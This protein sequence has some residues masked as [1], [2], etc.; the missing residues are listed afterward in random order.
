LLRY[1]APALDVSGDDLQVTALV[2]RL[3]QG[4]TGADRQRATLAQGGLPAVTD[5]ITA[6]SMP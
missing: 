3:L 4:G 1:V 2:H 5:L 6:R